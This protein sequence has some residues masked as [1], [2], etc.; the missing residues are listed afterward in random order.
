MIGDDAFG[1]RQKGLADRRVGL[2]VQAPGRG[3]LAA[4]ID[5]TAQSHG[6]KDIG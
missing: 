3:E 6:A 4:K 5:R 1:A 2:A